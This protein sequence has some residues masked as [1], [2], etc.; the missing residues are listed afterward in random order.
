MCGLASDFEEVLVAAENLR[1]AQR[2]YM[3]NRGNDELGREVAR[4][5]EALDEAI[6]AARAAQK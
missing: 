2:A 6:H 4:T 1:A 3:A 5:A